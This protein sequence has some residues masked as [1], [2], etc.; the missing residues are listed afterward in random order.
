[1]TRVKTIESGKQ[2]QLSASRAGRCSADQEKQDDLC[3][4]ANRRNANASECLNIP[5]STQFS[6]FPGLER[7]L[8][9]EFAEN[10]DNIIF[11]IS[12]SEDLQD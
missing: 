12:L 8:S 11:F 5:Y 7:D 4:L 3:N 2:L 1:M 10:T 9:D 6:S